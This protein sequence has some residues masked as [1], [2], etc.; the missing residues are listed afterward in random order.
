[1]KKLLI[2]YINIVGYIITGLVFALSCFIL[3]VNLYHGKEV[4]N[5]FVKSEGYIDVYTKNKEKIEKIK[6]NAS[7]FNPNFYR[8]EVDQTD[9]IAI[10][11]KLDMCASKYEQTK[12]NKIF[13]KEK[14]NIQDVYQLLNFYQSDIVN[15]CVTLQIY[16]MNISSNSARVQSF[17]YMK[18][19][20]VINSKVLMNDLS[21]VKRVLQNNSSYQFS[22]D[23][24]K[25][26]IFNMTRDSYT[27]IESS[28]QNSID[29]VYT[30]SEWFNQIIRGNG[31]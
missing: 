2:E 5:E 22:S 31:L 26:N 1:M 3:F 9:L 21:Y 23:Y 25:I 4:S 29:L 13:V 18:P 10:K 17:H 30:V 11:S 19:Y 20:I 15:D 12:A 8:G 14:I 16:S 6:N 28:Y 7:S 27:K 24:D